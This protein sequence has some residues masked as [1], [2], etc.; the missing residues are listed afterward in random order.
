MNHTPRTEPLGS[1]APTPVRSG[2]GSRS[3]FSLTVGCASVILGVGGFGVRAA[4]VTDRSE[5][6]QRR[7][8]RWTPEVALRHDLR[9]TRGIRQPCGEP[10]ALD[11]EIAKGH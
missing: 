8:P 6:L 2:S 10:S 9:E 4:V 5:V 3:P 11:D 7:R 1:D